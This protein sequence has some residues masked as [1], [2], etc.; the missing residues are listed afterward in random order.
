[1]LSK[2]LNKIIELIKPFKTLADI[3]SDHG[4]VP[5]NLLSNN[6]I[7]KAIIT[8]INQKPLNKAQNLLE[9][10]NLLDKATFRLG[11]G[12]EVLKDRCLEIIS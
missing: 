12:L 3:G 2:C 7:P 10:E 8:D 6:I 9:E 5:A 1:M 4:L 11:N